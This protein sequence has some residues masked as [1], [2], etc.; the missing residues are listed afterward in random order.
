MII[1]GRW[2]CC[3]LPFWKLPPHPARQQALLLFPPPSC[4]LLPSLLPKCQLSPRLNL[5][6]TLF[7][8]TILP[9][10]RLPVPDVF[11][12]FP[13]GSSSRG[14]FVQS[15]PVALEETE[16][17]SS[18]AVREPARKPWTLN[19]ASES[20]SRA[21]PRPHRTSHITCRGAGRCISNVTHT[22]PDLIFYLRVCS[23]ISVPG[24]LQF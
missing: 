16:A 23:S 15:P 4:R 12:A 2:P 20:G 1:R 18:Q 10:P 19:P 22:L 8:S 9:L 5:Q 6:F 14:H 17:Q 24:Y 13:T 7:S 3:P 21:T 11:M